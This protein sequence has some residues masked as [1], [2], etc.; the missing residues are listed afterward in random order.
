[1]K[2]I[3][4]AVILLS[5]TFAFSED[6]PQPVLPATNGPVNTNETGSYKPFK[7]DSKADARTGATR[8][9][10]KQKQSNP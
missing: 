10:K 5:A 7:A 4:T 2:T 8:K 9:S 1:M 3:L 6:R